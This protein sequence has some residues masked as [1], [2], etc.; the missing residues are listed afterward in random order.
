M[1]KKFGYAQFLKIAFIVG[2]FLCLFMIIRMQ[3]QFNE[4]N[5]R[6]EQLDIEVNE[7]KDTVDELQEEYDMAFDDEYVMKIAREKL[8]YHLPNEIIFYNDVY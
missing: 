6:K 2:A 8:N 4:L 7:A 1:K 3:F 5:D